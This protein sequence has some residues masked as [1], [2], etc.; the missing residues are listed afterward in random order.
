[1]T[2]ESENSPK[3]SDEPSVSPPAPVGGTGAGQAP[4]QTR[5]QF[6]GQAIDDY[7]TPLIGYASTLLNDTERAREVVQDT[8]SKLCH[9]PPEKVR[10][11]LKSWLFTVCRNRALDVLRKEKR[12]QPL[13]DIRWKKVAGPGLQPDEAAEQ[14]E[15]SA[16]LMRGLDRLTENQREVILLKF[17]QGLSYQDIHKITGLT[18]GNIGFLIHTGLKRLREI[19]PPDLR[20]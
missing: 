13:E 5:E 1:M 6:I 7:E 20:G 14:Q 15:Q 18:T 19:L 16:R 3:I 12:N 2:E 10:G 9:E 11:H 8:F 4:P 17:Q